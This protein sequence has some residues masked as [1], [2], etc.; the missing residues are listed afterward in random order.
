MPTT[1]QRPW[2]VFYFARG[3]WPLRRST[4]EDLQSWG[5]HADAPVIYINAAFGMRLEDVAALQPSRILFDTS[6]LKLRWQDPILLQDRSFRT[7]LARIDAAKILR[8]QDEFVDTDAI[9]EFACAIKA[10]LILSCA[11]PCEHDRLYPSA[12]KQGLAIKQVMTA[13]IDEA[14]RKRS[15][16]RRTPLSRRN[17]DLGYKAWRAT[18]W[19]G[20][21]A[22]LKVDIAEHALASSRTQA[23]RMAISLDPSDVVVGDDWLKFLESCKAV[24]GVEGGASI[25]DP[26]GQLRQAGI[27]FITRNPEA[28]FETIERACFAGRDGSFNLRCLS[29]RHLEAAAVGTCQFLVK[30]EYNHALTAGVHYVPIDPDLSNMDDVLA[31]FDEPIAMQAMSDRARHHVLNAPELSYRSFVKQVE[32]WSED[33]LFSTQPATPASPRMVMRLQRRDSLLM[34]RI[35]LEVWLGKKPGLRR[36]LSPLRKLLSK[37]HR[38]LKK[39]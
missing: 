26:D 32:Q 30:G 36:L 25:H 23:L 20:R 1:Y 34:K 31:S 21:H 8:P 35:R 7:E 33:K 16:T 37:T 9:D 3:A 18:P 19:L 14:L 38:Q 13:Y 39:P 24:I 17:I 29:P 22:K 4:W 2:I 5:R 11:P 15:L 12:R 27:D 10:D 28:D 6:F